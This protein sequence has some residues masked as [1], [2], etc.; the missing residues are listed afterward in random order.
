MDTQVDLAEAVKLGA[1]DANFF[2]QFFFP[3]ACR[4]DAPEFHRDLDEKLDSAED[5]FVSAM[6]A[7]GFAKTTKLR[8]YIARRIAYRISRTIVIVGKSEGAAVKTVKWLQRAVMYNYQYSSTFSLKR[9]ATWT[10]SEVEIIAEER[11]NRGN[12][13][14]EV[15]I[16]ILAIGITGSVRGINVD[17]YRPDLI[18]VDDPCDEEN[19]ATIEQR[20][21]IED[22]FFGALAKS[23]APRVDSPFAKMVLLQTVLN[24]DDLVSKCDKDPQWAS[25]KF[26]CFTQDKNGKEVSRWPSRFPTEDLLADKAAHIHRNQ[27][28][29][30]LREMECK[31]VSEE[32]A[33][34]RESWLQHWDTLPNAGRR[35]LCIDPTP[36][37]KQD[38][39][40]L[41]PKLDDAVIMA[42]QITKGQFFVLEY[43]TMKSPDPLEF[44][45]NIFSMARRWKIKLAGFETVLF[46]RVLAFFFRNEMKKEKFWLTVQEVEDKRSK[47][48][49]ISQDVGSVAAAGDLFIKEDMH[50]LR[51][52]FVEFPDVN[53]DDL[54]DA[55]SIGILTLS[56]YSVIEID[57]W[58]EGEYEEI[59]DPEDPHG[60]LEWVR[61][62]P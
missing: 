33:A 53:H 51:A 38:A 30:W 6:I 62:V 29:L 48:I 37:P 7:R 1:V 24:K 2:G 61:G 8:V 35:C 14:R 36:P 57:D 44:I 20:K 18:V 47:P 59:H 41:N 45:S 50:E 28:P 39:T 26:S 43:Y 4:Q 19:T 34:F 46:Q 27:L 31:V 3:K 17:D 13:V 22:L 15:P 16:T 12:V 11:D 5:R 52:Q 10:G 23:L 56:K 58:L 54:L 55:V 9:G 40:S 60:K 32:T 49:R 42:M 25:L 21:K